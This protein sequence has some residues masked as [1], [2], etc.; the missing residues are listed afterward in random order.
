MTQRQGARG[1]IAEKVAGQYPLADTYHLAA[2]AREM[3]AITPRVS[4]LV[5]AGTGLELSGDPS[6]Q[7]ISRLEWV[8]RNVASFG[9]LIEPATRKLIER[10]ISEDDRKQSIEK[11]VQRETSAILGFLSRRVLGQYELVLPTG[12]DGDSVVYVGANLLRMERAHQF[13]PSDF[14]FWVALHELTHRAQFLG[15]P[16]MRGYFRG[17]VDELV[18]AS[19]PEPGQFRG[20]L[21]EVVERA[22]KGNSLIDERGL[23][24]LFATDAQSEIV[25]RVQALMTLL[26]GHGHVVMDRIGAAHLK[27]Q[28][29]M[30]RV[31]KN[32]RKDKRTAAFFRL[33]GIEMKMN[34]YKNGE[35]FIETVERE[36]GWEAVNLAFRGASSLPTLSEINQP[37]LWLQRVA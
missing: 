31:L 29:R 36:A 4:D 35:S 23:F 30:S 37:T 3:A 7:I 21:A 8:D 2:L 20:A 1:R 10:R 33:T 26:E 25:D 13:R 27:S 22:R 28:E 18:E 11:L 5:S 14:R 16:W 15:I 12:E 9:H 34:Q 6:T 17:L 32:R 24:G 19:G